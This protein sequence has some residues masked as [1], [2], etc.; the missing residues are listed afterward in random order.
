M[1]QPAPFIFITCQVGAE[2]AVKHEIARCWPGVRFAYSRPGFL[3]F[4]LPADHGLADDFDLAGVFARAYGF[5]LGKVTGA[6]EEDL[7]RAAWAL[8]AHVPATR[9]HVWQRDQREP[10]KFGYEPGL[11]AP[12]V[13]ARAALAEAAPP[14]FTTIVAAAPEARPG[15]LVLDCV[16]VSPSEWWLG[17]HR[18]HN[19]ASCRA[20]GFLEIALPAAAV[21]RAY[22]KMEEALDWSQMPIRH[23]DRVVELGCAPGGSCQALLAR[24]FVVTGIDPA[25]VDPAVLAD[26]SF[27]HVRKRAGD[28]RRREFRD[29]RWL[30][31]D[32][33]VAPQ[34]TLDAVEAIVAHREVRINGVIMT[35]KLFDWGLAD[36]LPHYM[37]RVRSW[38]FPQVAARQLQHSRQEVCVAAH[39]DNAKPR[40]DRWS[41]RR[42][43]C[44]D[45]G[46]KRR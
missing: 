26:P 5:T 12:A 38:G 3:T 9:L 45:R 29:T 28:V 16:L 4:K 40:R 32:M 15:E 42:R 30:V 8:A 27:T 35:L 36:E 18:A 44:G 20:G 39:K 19:P 33:N 17:Y 2:T 43:I 21:S 13:A 34:Y 11:S 22:L 24:G 7:A 37:D 41:P 6:T 14:E 1:P 31:A 23:G 46:A 10:G 25:E